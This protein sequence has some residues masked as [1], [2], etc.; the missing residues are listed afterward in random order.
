MVESGEHFTAEEI[1]DRARGGLPGLE[2]STVYRALETLREAGLVAES[3]LPAGP[4]VF[5]AR[6][7]SHPHL[8]CEVCGE[9]SHPEGGAGRRLLEAL[10]GASEG[11]EVR[12][13]HVT[14][15]GV[16]AGCAGREG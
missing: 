9:I 2:L 8:V 5:E 3:R 16:C 4:R 6:P 7:S 1:W 14:A 15:R 13:L 11:F 10:D 12:E